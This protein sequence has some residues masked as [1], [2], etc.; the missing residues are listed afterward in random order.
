MSSQE[1]KRGLPSTHA[2]SWPLKS[3]ACPL[4][5]ASR[6]QA[7]AAAAPAPAPVDA[8]PRSFAGMSAELRGG[9]HPGQEG[10][11]EQRHGERPLAAHAR[12]GSLRGARL[13]AQ[14]ESPVT[15]RPWVRKVAE[16]SAGNGSTLSPGGQLRPPRAQGAFSHSCLKTLC[17]RRHSLLK[18]RYVSVQ[19]Y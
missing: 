5:A 4:A 17:T 3:P 11:G 16:V 15:G 1:M 18:G 14:A 12:S 6:T 9:L 7:G 13:V 19:V 8:S 2:S 10:G